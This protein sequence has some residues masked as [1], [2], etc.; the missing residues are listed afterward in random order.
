MLANPRK[1]SRVDLNTC[2][3]KVLSTLWGQELR[4]GLGLCPAVASM[5]AL[6]MHSPDTCHLNKLMSGTVK[7]VI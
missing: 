2:A 7:Y 5:V 6:K 3:L 4:A 1:G